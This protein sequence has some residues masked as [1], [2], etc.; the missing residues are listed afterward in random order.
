MEKLFK[1]NPEVIYLNS[2]SHSLVPH[3]A[4]EKV[5]HYLD[6]YEKNPTQGLFAA[7]GRLW[8]VQ[9]SIAPEFGADPKNFFFRANVTQALNEFI[10]GLELP[11]SCEILTSNQ[12]YGAIYNICR[13][14]A[15]RDGFGL[16]TFLMP[17]KKEIVSLSTA[18]LVDRVVSSFRPETKLLVISDIYTSNGLVLPIEAICREAR[19]RGILT[20]VDGAHS[21]G[22]LDLN[23][24][25]SQMD[26]YA[27]NLHKWWMGP[28]GTAFG[29]FRRD[30]FKFLKAIQAGWVSYDLREPYASFAEGDPAAI[31]TMMLGCQDFS[32]FFALPEVKAFWHEQGWDQIRN[33]KKAL[34]TQLVHEIEDALGFFYFTSRKDPSLQGPLHAF[35]LPEKYGRMPYVDLINN[36]REKTKVQ[37]S[38]TCM[39]DEAY[40]RLSPHVYNTADEIHEAAGN[41]KDYFRD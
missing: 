5:K 31:R 6:E 19:A 8:E 7:C 33:K 1:K 17:N 20:V 26:F 11:K 27:G 28:K 12:E 34:D 37:C 29:W 25:K 14:R 9:K 15:E 24:E 18:D 23:L 35:L 36:I 16:R 21:P 32:P 30:S 22:N 13:F 2:G 41:L 4:L 38:I 39:Y 10:L 40:L 3:R